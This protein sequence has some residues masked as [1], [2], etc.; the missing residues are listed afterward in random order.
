MESRLDEGRGRWPP[1]SWFVPASFRLPGSSML[2]RR[3][4]IRAGAAAGAGACLTSTLG[5]WRRVLAQVPGGT[6][7]P[8]AIQKF[9]TRLPIPAAMPRTARDDSTDYYS[10]AVRHFEQ[11]ILPS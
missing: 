3:T 8:D 9:V 2:N 4:L 1:P 6:L 7:S 11:Q 10:I 5:L